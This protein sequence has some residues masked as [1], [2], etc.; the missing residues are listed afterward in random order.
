MHTL[1]LNQFKLLEVALELPDIWK[2]KVNL[3]KKEKEIKN[4][5]FNGN[6]DQIA[7]LISFVATGGLLYMIMNDRWSYIDFD[8]RQNY[9]GLR[10]ERRVKDGLWNGQTASPDRWRH[11]IQSYDS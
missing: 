1:Y 7:G 5:Q 4:W 9:I 2:S 10:S 11:S 3:H 8:G 6:I